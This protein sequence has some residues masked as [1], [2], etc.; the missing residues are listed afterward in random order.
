[1]SDGIS[2]KTVKELDLLMKIS[3]NALMVVIA[4]FI[5]IVHAAPASAIE[6]TYNHSPQTLNSLG[7]MAYDGTTLTFTAS[8]EYMTSQSYWSNNWGIMISD[9]GDFSANEGHFCGS[10]VNLGYVSSNPAY[11]RNDL[12]NAGSWSY[13]PTAPTVGQ[14]WYVVL[15]AKVYTDAPTMNNYGYGHSVV[16]P[17]V[18]GTPYSEEPP[19]ERL[20]P[21]FSWNVPVDSESYKWSDLNN[22]TYMLNGENSYAWDSA[23]ISGTRITDSWFLSTEEDGIIANGDCTNNPIWN[24][25]H[26]IQCSIPS[27]P[28]IKNFLGQWGYIFPNSGTYHLEGY[29]T[30]EWND[31][32]NLLEVGGTADNTYVS[33]TAELDFTV[34]ESGAYPTESMPW[35]SQLLLSLFI[36]TDGHS[37]LYWMIDQIKTQFNNKIPFAY[38]V[39]IKEAYLDKIEDVQYGTSFPIPFPQMDVNGNVQTVNIDVGSIQQVNDVYD[40]VKPLISVAMWFAWALWVFGLAMGF[41]NAHWIFNA[42]L[43]TRMGGPAGWDDDL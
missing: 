16:I 37:G 4:A 14:T 35:Y 36:P 32:T 25:N 12:T 2:D 39:E 7:T 19:D 27:G 17:I 3:R 28:S 5:V 38:Y 8:S 31:S 30:Y 40:I 9:V 10:Q 42:D 11:T 29:V 1:M 43:K 20:S 41:I 22:G 23:Y 18:I 6:Y 34:T 13:C 33:E 24:N 21:T 26:T 15:E